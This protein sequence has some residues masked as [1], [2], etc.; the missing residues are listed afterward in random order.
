MV[1]DR[2]T[3]LL[4]ER[5]NSGA[6]AEAVCHLLDHPN[7]AMRMGRE[8]RARMLGEFRHGDYVDAYDRLYRR[9]AA[10]RPCRGDPGVQRR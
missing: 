1:V 7:D 5:E 6:L 2:K 10:R 9:I 8:A 3:G 4:V